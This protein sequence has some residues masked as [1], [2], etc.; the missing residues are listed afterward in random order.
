MRAISA[1]STPA[2]GAAAALGLAVDFGLGPDFGLGF[3][4]DLAMS[5]CFPELALLLAGRGGPRKAAARK[6]P[7]IAGF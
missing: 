4:F 5:W 7:R 3:R 2:R 6:W 1:P